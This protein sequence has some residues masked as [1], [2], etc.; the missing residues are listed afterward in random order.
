MPGGRQL[1]YLCP[2]E[3]RTPT[4]FHCAELPLIQSEG[5]GRSFL[6]QPSCEAGFVKSGWKPK[7]ILDLHLPKT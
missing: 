3:R 4:L 1:F 2:G 7:N 6:S 5:E